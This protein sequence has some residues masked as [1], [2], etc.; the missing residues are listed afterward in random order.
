M[1]QSLIHNMHITTKM[2]DV[3]TFQSPGRTEMER[4]AERDGDVSVG[5]SCSFKVLINAYELFR[6]S[7][8]SLSLTLIPEKSK[9]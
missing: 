9:S 5:N 2:F 6:A 4:D 7:C 3:T 8:E 1:R